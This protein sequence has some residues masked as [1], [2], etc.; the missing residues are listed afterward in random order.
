MD[1]GKRRFVHPPQHPTAAS[2]PDAQTSAET[3]RDLSPARHDGLVDQQQTPP[4]WIGEPPAGTDLGPPHKRAPAGLWVQFIGQYAYFPVLWVLRGLLGVFGFLA[5]NGTPWSTIDTQTGSLWLS[6]RKLRLE[7]D[8]TAAE[9]ESWA[10]RQLDEAIERS[11]RVRKARDPGKLG[12]PPV[13]TVSR[14]DRRQLSAADVARIAA[15]RGWVVVWT[16]QERADRNIPLAPRAEAAAFR[17][18]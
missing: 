9:W 16:R 18:G 6:S 4:Y 13:V 5:G 14:A 10:G 15:E 11:V 1:V 2:D 8:G 3:A 12:P 17:R 7:L